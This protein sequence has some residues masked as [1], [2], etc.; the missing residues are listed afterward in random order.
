[1]KDVRINGRMARVFVLK[2]T[3]DRLV[4]IPLNSIHRV[5]YDRLLDVEAI[6]SRTKTDMLDVM[7]TYKLD[8]GRNAL[9]QYDSIIQVLQKTADIGK[10]SVGERLEKPGEAV[11]KM[12]VQAT[13]KEAS[14]V[15]EGYAPQT[16]VVPQNQPK[17]R[18]P[19]PKPKAPIAE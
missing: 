12:E 10:I 6:A 5:D 18:G 4:Y 9:L 7:S 16:T 3:K 8:N 15:N 14:E 13:V 2:E 19:K 11:I 1:M 17:K